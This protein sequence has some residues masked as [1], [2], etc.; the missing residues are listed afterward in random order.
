MTPLVVENDYDGHGNLLYKDK[1][2]NGDAEDYQY[3][4]GRPHAVSH[5]GDKRYYYDSRG[6]M[7]RS[8]SSDG[9]REISWYSFDKPKSITQRTTGED[10]SIIQ[11]HYDADRTRVAK[12]SHKAI[13]TYVGGSYERVRKLDGSEIHKYYYSAGGQSIGYITQHLNSAKTQA[14]T[15]EYY[16]LTDHLGST[17]VMVKSDGSVEQRMS[18]S[19]WGER[20][21]AVRWSAFSLSDLN[22]MLGFVDDHGMTKGYTGHEQDDEVGLI[23]MNG[24]LYDAALGRFISADPYVQAPEMTQSFNRYTYVLNNPL[25]YVD[26]SGYFWGSVGRAARSVGRAIGYAA[27]A[28][29]G[30]LRSSRAITNNRPSASAS[31]SVA[32][33]SPW[34]QVVN[35]SAGLGYDSVKSPAITIPTGVENVLEL[36]KIAH[37]DM[38]TAWKQSHVVAKPDV[39]EHGGTLIESIKSAIL[40]VTNRVVGT[41]SYVSLDTRNI[42]TGNV[43]R[44]AYHTHP[45]NPMLEGAPPS[46]GDLH[47]AMHFKNGFVSFVESGNRRFAIEVVDEVVANKLAVTRGAKGLNDSINNLVATDQTSHSGQNKILNHVKSY[48]KNNNTGLKLYSTRDKAKLNFKEEM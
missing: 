38:N 12:F 30:Y 37:G 39:K 27:R 6:N 43:L 10:S 45:Y 13:T 31:S 22:H 20:R 32:R 35:Q 42:G 18:F 33:Q 16:L 11:M 40:S 15:N 19:A 1:V 28:I 24:R 47:H 48:L 17:D 3:V 36:A 41:S 46:G 5:V 8:T 34:S 14:V 44:G 25:G 23:N 9:E 26:P 29:G 7:T 4:N 2:Q 21:H